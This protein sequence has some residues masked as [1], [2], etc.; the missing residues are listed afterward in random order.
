MRAKVR[1]ESWMGAETVPFMN[2][3]QFSQ[4]EFTR[5]CAASGPRGGV[6]ATMTQGSAGPPPRGR[7]A[8][9]A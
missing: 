2:P 9:R 7:G 8:G 6:F 5:S 4:R 3:I 1:A